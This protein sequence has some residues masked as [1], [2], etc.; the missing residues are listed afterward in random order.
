MTEQ[1]IREI[2]GNPVFISLSDYALKLRRNLIALSCVAVFYKLSGAQIIHTDKVT[3]FG[4]T[5]SGIKQNFLDVSCGCYLCYS[6][7]HYVFESWEIFLRW[8]IRLSGTFKE[9][10][11]QTTVTASMSINTD[12]KERIELKDIGYCYGEQSY[13]YSVLAQ[14]IYSN[15]NNLSSSEPERQI[16]ALHQIL[17]TV[18]EGLD[19]FQKSFK[20]FQK[21]QVSRFFIFDVFVPFVAVGTAI[22]FL[23]H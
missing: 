1:S 16:R 10:I 22:F 17:L 12:I 7:F 5:F 9:V 18:K 21:M 15:L 19:R 2:L 13:L 20:Q 4:F 3:L 8:K 23:I 11:K 14:I 6:F